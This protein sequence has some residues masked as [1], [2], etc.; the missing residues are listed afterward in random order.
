MSVGVPVC[1]FSTHA[2]DISFLL[3]E[4]TPYPRAEQITAVR[5]AYDM[6]LWP[7]KLL[8]LWDCKVVSAPKSLP[9]YGACILVP[10]PP[11]WKHG[12]PLEVLLVGKNQVY[13]VRIGLY[14]GYTSVRG[15]CCMF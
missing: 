7:D 11:S 15:Y 13:L 6:R 8:C 12:G 5:S 4:L 2:S 10:I 9:G 1:V 14:L 3:E